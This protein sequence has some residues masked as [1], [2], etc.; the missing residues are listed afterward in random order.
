MTSRG[1]TSGRL[2]CTFRTKYVSIFSAASK[3]A[4]TPSRSG[5]TGV[6]LLGVRPSISWASVPTASI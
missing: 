6:I 3:S 1:R 5:R 4:I 2:P